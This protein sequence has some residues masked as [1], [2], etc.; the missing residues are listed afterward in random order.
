M[1]DVIPQNGQRWLICGGRDFADA[2]MFNAA[3]GDLIRVKGCPSV[4]IHGG[5]PGAD[6][7]A[8]AWAERMAVSRHRFPAQWDKHGK[9]AGPIRNQ[10]MID[11]G[12]PH[13]VIA[14]PG[15]SGT[16]DMVRRAREAGI[17]VAEIIPDAKEGERG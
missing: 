9:A 17:D 2:A 4:I 1:L 12:R 3:M 14:F 11:K 8:E 7:F 10:A 6:R 13:F 5:A 15:G 16:A